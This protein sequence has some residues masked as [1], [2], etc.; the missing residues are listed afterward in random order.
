MEV[1]FARKESQLKLTEA[2]PRIAPQTGWRLEYYASTC[3]VIHQDGTEDSAQIGQDKVE[4]A[5]THAEKLSTDYLYFQKLIFKDFHNFCNA[6]RS[7]INNHNRLKA[8]PSK[9]LAQF[10]STLK[11]KLVCLHS[12]ETVQGPKVS[13]RRN[14]Q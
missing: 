3:A 4:Q 8:V 10:Q 2:Q 5:M 14:I 6:N 1:S 9:H 12:V 7:P 13:G 11:N